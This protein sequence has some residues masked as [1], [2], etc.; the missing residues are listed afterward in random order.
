VRQLLDARGRVAH[1]DAT[2]GELEVFLQRY[3]KA[4]LAAQGETALMD[5]DILGEAVT[6]CAW[7]EQV[8]DEASDTP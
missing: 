6:W 5:S 4:Y 2:A 7:A 1:D 8:L 3:E